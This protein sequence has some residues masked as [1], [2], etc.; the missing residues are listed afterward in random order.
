VATTCGVVEL[1]LLGALRDAGTYPA[2]A[3]LRRQAFPT[4]EMSEADV[5]R[6]Q[7]IQAL[8]AEHGL[9]WP[10]LLVAAVA[11]RHEVTVLHG[12]SQFDVIARITGQRVVSCIGA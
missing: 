10:A 1:H 2:I 12:D 6:A 3:D 7:Q 8:A 4:L 11:E 9:S 5:Q